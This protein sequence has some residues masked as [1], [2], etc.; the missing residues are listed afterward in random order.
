MDVG[1]KRSLAQ[2]IFESFFGRPPL[3]AL[4]KPLSVHADALGRVLVVDSGWRKVLVFDFD[5]ELLGII[6][7]KGRGLLLNPLGVTTDERGRIYV[8]DAGG[9]RVLVYNSEGNFLTAF[10]GRNQLVRP[11]GIAVNST[12]GLVYVV[13]TWAHQIKVFGRDTGNLLFTI[14]RQAE[15]PVDLIE[16]ALDQTWNRGDGDAEFRFP[17]WIA[18][19]VDGQLYVVDTMNFRVQILAPNGKFIRKFGEPGNWPGS[20]FRPKGIG[21]DSEGHIYVADAAFNNVQIFDQEGR[22]LLNFGT[23]GSGLADL[24]LP[25]GLYVDPQDRIYVV[26]QYNHRVQVYQYLGGKPRKGEEQIAGKERR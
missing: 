20:F 4:K 23:F 22:L 14:G 7:D 18:I 2:K 12:L 3:R 11:A 16:G 17:T 5:K 1:W 26:D 15:R 24:R 25:A 10:G 21:L 13:D 19:G 9:K 6:G 8:T